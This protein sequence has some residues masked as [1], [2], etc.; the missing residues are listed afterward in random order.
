MDKTQKN[1]ET[2]EVGRTYQSVQ[3]HIETIVDEDY[4]DTRSYHTFRGAS[5][6]LY[7]HF[8][9]CNFRDT[10]DFDLVELISLPE[11]ATQAY[12]IAPLVWVE[13]EAK[14]YNPAKWE[15]VAGTLR[16]KIV[17]Y[18]A[19]CWTVTQPKEIRDVFP[20]LEEAKAY[21]QNHHEA[22]VKKFLLPA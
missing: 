7:S 5:G 9:S 18:T 8:G 2:L 6:R 14:L 12:T 19:R 4:L 3:G 16:F 17:Q 10:R 21:C 20:T 11:P 1:F 22:E 13:T 15:V